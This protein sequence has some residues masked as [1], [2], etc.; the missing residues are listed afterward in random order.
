VIAGPQQPP[1][2]PGQGEERD[3]L[4]GVRG[5]DQPDPCV[6]VTEAGDRLPEFMVL[7]IHQPR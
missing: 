3:P 4:A 1:L 5:K 2:H 6:T 7:G